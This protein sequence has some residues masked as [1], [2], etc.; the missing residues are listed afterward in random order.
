[1]EG[2]VI[3]I[4]PRLVGSFKNGCSNESKLII[5]QFMQNYISDGKMVTTLAVKDIFNCDS[6]FLQFLTK[7]I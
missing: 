1:M 2:Q 5:L 7:N 6:I 3:K 4:S